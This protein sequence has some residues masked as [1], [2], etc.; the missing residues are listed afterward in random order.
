MTAPRVD[1]SYEAFLR[2]QQ[3]QKKPVAPQAPDL[4]YEAFQR[5]QAAAPK[6]VEGVRK[7][8]GKLEAAGIALATGLLP[9]SLA[10]Y[11]EQFRALT[12]PP[13]KETPE[14]SYTRG[15]KRLGEREAQAKEALGELPYGILNLAG[16]IKTAGKFPGMAARAASDAPR[17]AKALA[18][19]KRVAGGAALAGTES[20]SRQGMDSE[21]LSPGEAAGLAAGLGLVGESIV[22]AGRTLLRGAAQ[23]PVVGQLGSQLVRGVTGPVQEVATQARRGLAEYFGQRGPLGQRVAAAVEPT[24]VTRI[25][26]TV[27]STLPARGQTVEQ[28]AQQAALAEERRIALAEAAGKAESAVTEFGKKGASVATRA[29]EQAGARAKQTAEATVAEL[30]QQ[31][32]RKFGGLTN[33]AESASA[34]RQTVI[35]R[36]DQLGKQVYTAVQAVKPLAQPPRRIYQQIDK[37]GDLSSAFQYA[38]NTKR[39][40]LF[41]E[42]VEGAITKGADITERVKPERLEQYVLGQARNPATGELVD[43][44]RTKMD[45]EMF[46]YMRRWVSD[47]VEAG[48]TG[49]AEGITRSKAAGLKKQIDAMERDFL[50]AHSEADRKV[51]ETARKTMRDE[52]ENLELIRDGFNLQRFSLDATPEMRAAGAA[53]LAELIKEVAALP[54]AKRQYFEVPARQSIANLIQQS[55]RSVESIA[56]ALVGTTEARKRTALALGSEM[57]ATLEQYLPAKMKAAGASAAAPVTARGAARAQRIEQITAR[58][59]KTRDVEAQRLGAELSEQANRASQLSAMTQAAQSGVSALDDLTA[60]RGFS[61]TIPQ[62]LGGAG[63]R[64]VAG[65]MAGVLQDRL[66]GLS[67]QDAMA[68]LM[69]YQQ[70]PAAREMFGAELDQAIA[71]L[72]PRPSAIPSL[73]TYLTG[74]TVGRQ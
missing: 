52:F 26:R 66:R 67:P 44:K 10:G 31:A 19:G 7:P 37:N 61:A 45:L 15:M 72:R 60:A 17:L 34:L 39:A 68:K 22:P 57:T 5:A 23:I 21:Q 11:G 18:A 49:N 74:Q 56:G 63:R 71:R 6:A 54:A 30:E 2:S 4:S 48:L 38:E 8:M 41:G 58:G 20:A 14:D 28:M 25:Q 9:E 69:E 40:R 3:E 27:Q 51:L 59:Q 53:D 35:D 55:D 43:V 24:D 47:K 70:N 13:R 73:R 36:M 12:G 16:G 42:N 65:T 50:S 64:E 46:D 32:Q 62:S 29:V 33:P 1:L